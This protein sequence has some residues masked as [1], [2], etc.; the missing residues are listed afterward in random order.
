VGVEARAEVLEQGRQELAEWG[1]EHKHPVL[2]CAADPAEISLDTRFEFIW[3][4]SVLIHM[5]D[6][7]VKAYLALVSNTLGEDGKFYAN[8]QLGNRP[9]AEWQGFPVVSRPRE[10]YHR[11]AA[12][13]GLIVEDVGR[14]DT[15]GHRIGTGDRGMMLCFRRDPMVPS[16]SSAG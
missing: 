15:L 1:L 9:D 13:C 2:I 6:E 16:P 7:I 8:V 3:A 11:W 5:Q 10:S 14:L 12:A 4:F